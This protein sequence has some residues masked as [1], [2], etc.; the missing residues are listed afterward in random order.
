M[1][2]LLAACE[3]G[4]RAR[5]SKPARTATQIIYAIDTDDDRAI[6]AAVDVLRQRLD[7]LGVDGTVD[8][9]GS[10]IVV[11]V[12]GDGQRWR[13]SVATSSQLEL[14]MVDNDSAFMMSML[15][16][17]R[18][19]PEAARLGVTVELDYWRH[20]ASGADLR[21][22][23]FRGPD[24]LVIEQYVANLA[25]PAPPDRRIAYERI[26]PTEW[27]SYLVERDARVTGANIERA[28]VTWNPQTNRPEV[29]VDLDDAGQAAFADLT[30][31]NLGR[32]VAIL[33]DGRVTS[34]PV[35]Q[36][37]IPGGKISITMGDGDAKTLEREAEQLASALSSGALP[38]PVRE[39]S[40]TT[41]A[42]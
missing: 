37:R 8:A 10:D 28:S 22:A 16:Q 15:A 31:A 27:R 25:I 35:I 34:A 29:L 14:A 40:V 20:D 18:N 30:A 42:M 2:A 36:D 32:K 13:D 41:I 33:L 23:Y 4:D 7:K 9:R 11:E 5:K 17:A 26:S 21:D 24:R 1:F 12:E 6:R 38:A 3:D 19:D 39:I